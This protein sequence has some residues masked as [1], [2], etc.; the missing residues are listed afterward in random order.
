[1]MTV[2]LYH[3]ILFSMMRHNTIEKI[4]EN[5]TGKSLGIIQ[6]NDCVFSSSSIINMK[7]I[8]ENDGQT[9]L[10][11]YNETPEKII[12]VMPEEYNLLIM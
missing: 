7:C 1:M 6:N 9:P 8:Y 5:T 11:I 3:N 2:I 12:F 10:N 4:S